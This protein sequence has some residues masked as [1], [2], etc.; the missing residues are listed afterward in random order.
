[1]QHYKYIEDLG[2]PRKYIGLNVFKKSSKNKKE[3]K[4]FKKLKSNLE[5]N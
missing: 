4:R 3:K 2:I 1:M 5:K